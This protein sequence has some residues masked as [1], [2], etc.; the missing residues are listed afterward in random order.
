MEKYKKHKAYNLHVEHSQWLENLRFYSEELNFIKEKLA[1]NMTKKKSA[2]FLKQ[3]EHFQNQFIIQENEIAE[4]KHL[5]NEHERF[6]EK[7]IGYDPAAERKS[8]GDHMTER[9]KMEVFEKLFKE[10]KMD[11]NKFLSGMV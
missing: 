7:T 9:D 11:F 8:I 1:G 10:L 6:I 2:S 3:V 4:L 5:I